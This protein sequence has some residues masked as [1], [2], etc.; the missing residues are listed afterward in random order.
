[1][2]LHKDFIIQKFTKQILEVLP[3]VLNNQTPMIRTKDFN[4]LYRSTG[5]YYRC[6]KYNNNDGQPL[7]GKLRFN[8]FDAKK[9]LEIHD[10]REPFDEKRNYVGNTVLRSGPNA[11]VKTN[12][13]FIDGMGNIVYI[14]YKNNCKTIDIITDIVGSNHH[15]NRTVRVVSLPDINSPDLE[16]TLFQLEVSSKDYPFIELFTKFR[17]FRYINSDGKKT[18]LPNLYLNPDSDL[19][20]LLKNYKFST[21]IVPEYDFCI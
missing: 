4:S 10:S 21:E 8:V 17:L 14:E 12:V 18:R 20:S 11:D 19:D 5:F 16:A 6:G 15:T 1:M 7:N 2:K 9:G 3:L 13:V